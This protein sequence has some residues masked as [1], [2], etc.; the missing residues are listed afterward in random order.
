MP[1]R[2]LYLALFSTFGFSDPQRTLNSK[3]SEGFDV[4]SAIAHIY[5]K[6]LTIFFHSLEA[7]KT[8]ARI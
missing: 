7:C 4:A 1:R 8:Y 3:F 5:V 2:M 6:S